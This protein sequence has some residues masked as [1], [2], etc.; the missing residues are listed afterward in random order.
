M[1]GINREY[2]SA[3]V[4]LEGYLTVKEAAEAW[5]ASVRTIQML[6]SQGR[7]EGVLKVGNMWLIPKESSLPSDGRIRTGKY[8]NWRENNNKSKEDL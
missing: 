6:C 3:E 7:I 1:I 8:V 4:I 5:K 2:L